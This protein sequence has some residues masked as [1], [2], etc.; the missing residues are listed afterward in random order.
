[1]DGNL[2]S[3]ASKP[4]LDTRYRLKTFDSRRVYE[5]FVWPRPG[6]LR[7]RSAD[8]SGKSAVVQN[9]DAR[10]LLAIDVKQIER[11]AINVDGVAERVVAN[12]SRDDSSWSGRR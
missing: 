5:R 12:A 6:T 7:A 9:N 8:A 1:M 4:R 11:G 3:K 10:P 2:V